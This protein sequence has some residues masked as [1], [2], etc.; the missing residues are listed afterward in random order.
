M[1]TILN[2]IEGLLIG[3]VGGLVVLYGLQPKEAYPKWM[4]LPYDHPWMFLVMLFVIVYTA[5]Y[6]KTL[7]ALLL[8]LAVSLYVDL[9]L[10]GRPTIFKNDHDEDSST[11]EVVGSEVHHQEGV[12]LSNVR[13][14]V[15]NYPLFYGL[16][17][18]QPGDPAP[19]TS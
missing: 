6:S 9:I 13:L 18:S 8:L 11:I 16:N 7:S 5:F 4:L 15:P 10:F 1:G 12:P 3:V 17:D 19:F 14:D 2:V